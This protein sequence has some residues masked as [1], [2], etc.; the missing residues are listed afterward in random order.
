LRPGDSVPIQQLIVVPRRY[1]ALL[2]Q[3]H[4]LFHRFPNSGRVN[5]ELQ[6]KDGAV[7]LKS[8]DS[9]PGY[10]GIDLE[11]YFGV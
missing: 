11:S 3:V 7:S 4:L 8:E 9:S 5:V 2:L 10:F 6:N 1:D